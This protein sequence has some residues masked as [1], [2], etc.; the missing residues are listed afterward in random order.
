MTG[1]NPNQNDDQFHARPRQGTSS[2]FQNSQA[3]ADLAQFQQDATAQRN[4]LLQQQVEALRAQLAESTARREAE[5]KQLREAYEVKQSEF[6]GQLQLANERIS[7]V[8]QEAMEARQALAATSQ[9][10]SENASLRNAIA[11]KDSEV[12]RLRVELGKANSA[13][14]ESLKYAREMFARQKNEIASLK[15]QLDD[16]QKGVAANAKESTKLQDKVIKLEAVVEEKTSQLKELK[17]EL[18]EA[19]QNNSKLE[20]QIAGA[21]KQYSKLQSANEALHDNELELKADVKEIKAEV[22]VRDKEIKELERELAAMD[23][24]A[25]RA[26]VAF[27]RQL[28]ASEKRYNSALA[29]I[30]KRDDDVALLKERIAELRGRGSG[31]ST[32]KSSRSRAAKKSSTKRPAKKSKTA[33]KKTVRRAVTKKVAKKTTK[34]PVKKAKKK[35]AKK[36]R[37]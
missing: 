28:A 26:E 19:E 6:S 8:Q 31:K 27:E 20:K 18:R 7:V 35:T 34:K 25:Q 14:D 1:E 5:V 17:D 22:S 9:A 33:K 21:E 30:E 15:E 29:K 10:S 11:E 37:R 3:D 2:E 23:K 24:Q 32:P 12:T 4:L 16:H 13:S 36:R